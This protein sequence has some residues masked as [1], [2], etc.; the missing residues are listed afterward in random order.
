MPLQVRAGFGAPEVYAV[1]ARARELCDRAAGEQPLF[2]VLWGLWLFHKV[3]SEL[4]RARA[5]ADE[6]RALA[7]RLA[8]PALELQ[9][10]QA[11]AVTALCRGEPASTV[12][13]MEQAAALYDPQ[14]HR[15]HSSQFGQ[16]PGVACKSFGSV[17]LWLL[18]H[19]D[20]AA[21]LSAETVRLA[22]ELGQPSSLALALFFAA[23]VHQCRGSGPRA[24]VNAEAC[25]FAAAEH[26]F[27][28]WLAGATVLSGWALSAS[29]DDAEGVARLRRGLADWSATG[30][31]TYQTYFMGLLAEVL[32]R[33]QEVEE[34]RHVLTEA[35]ALSR[36]TGE[37]LYEA[38]LHRLDGELLRMTGFPREA[39]ENFRRALDVARSQGA[40]SFELRAAASLT[41]LQG[42]SDARTLLTDTYGRFT[43]GFETPDLREARALLAE[44]P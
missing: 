40:Q 23:V 44:L 28:F 42:D 7:A 4:G 1:Y 8:Q 30:S 16:D 19:S 3:R 13:H 35:L 11:L 33:R 39:A 29:G 25:R 32:L 9:A 17:A 12:R 20:E 41:R 37:R 2:A 34:A 6:L 15:G 22:R 26:G 36:R 5:M 10:Q 38:E 43:E 27:S 31:V 24:L 18:G 21:R 14:R